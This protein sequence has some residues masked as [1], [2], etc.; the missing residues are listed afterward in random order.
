M[1]ALRIAATIS[2][3]L[4]LVGL[5]VGQTTPPTPVPNRDGAAV[6]ELTGLVSD[7]ICKGMHFRKAL[8]PFS[9]TLNCV[10]D[11]TDYALI[12]GDTVYILEGHRPEL[13]KFA[14]GPRHDQ[15]ASEWKPDRGG[16][17]DES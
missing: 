5:A 12:V 3:L 9:C 10:H 2:G 13:D 8:T 1:K 4:V 11:G 6:E 17:G 14:G 15:R 7:A 16:L